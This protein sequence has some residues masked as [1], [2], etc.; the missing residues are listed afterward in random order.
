MDDYTIYILIDAGTPIGIPLKR[1]TTA[2]MTLLHL[3]LSK[4][5]EESGSELFLAIQLVH[6]QKIPGQ[7]PRLEAINKSGISPWA[8]SKS[9]WIYPI[10]AR[11]R[12]STLIGG[13]S[14]F[15]ISKANETHFKLSCIKASLRV[16]AQNDQVPY[17][18]PI[19]AEAQFAS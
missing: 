18:A 13:Q 3:I 5:I 15:R 12:W 8:F 11:K 10:L 14:R 1:C 4:P 17:S 19:F 6:L 16:L 2:G 9:Y 7:A